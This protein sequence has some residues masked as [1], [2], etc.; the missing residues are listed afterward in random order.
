[1]NDMVC[2]A[3]EVALGTRNWRYFIGEK[4]EFSPEPAAFPF[5]VVTLI[6]CLRPLGSFPRRLV[7]VQQVSAPALP[8]HGRARHPGMN[9][10]RG[11]SFMVTGWRQ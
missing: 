11:P 7:F 3:S 1:M 2:K 8:L 6:W 9:K 10:E 5:R 4:L